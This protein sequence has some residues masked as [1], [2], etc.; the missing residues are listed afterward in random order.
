MT[1]GFHRDQRHSLTL[2]ERALPAIG[3]AETMKV[4][5]DLEAVLTPSRVEPAPTGKWDV[6]S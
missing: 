1:G 3:A 6:L 2:W 4:L 5:V